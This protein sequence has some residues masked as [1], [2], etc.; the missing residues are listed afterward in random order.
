[1]LSPLD[2]TP[3][4]QAGQVCGHRMRFFPVKVPGGSVIANT[5][6]VT[7]DMHRSATQGR[8]QDFFSN[9]DYNDETYLVQNMMPAPQ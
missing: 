8:P 4:C 3:Q 6:I 7:V 9:Y 1:M 2:I 5:W